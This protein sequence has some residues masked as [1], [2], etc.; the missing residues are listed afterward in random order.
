MRLQGEKE[1]FEN[2]LSGLCITL[3]PLA[4][5]I[6]DSKFYVDEYISPKADQLY[7]SYVQRRDFK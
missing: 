3:I 4:S 2:K 7:Q 1:W 6:I 5:R